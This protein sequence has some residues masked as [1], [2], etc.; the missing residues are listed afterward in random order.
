MQTYTIR[1]GGGVALHV[2]EIGPRDATP[3]LFIHGFSQC[4]LAWRKQTRSDLAREFRLITLDLRGHGASTRP[5]DGYDDPGLWAEDLNAV[6]DTLHLNA[7][8]LVGW[9]Y[10]GVIISDYLRVYGEDRVAGVQLVGAVSRLG[11]PLVSGGFLGSDFLAVVPALFSNDATESV[12]A[13]TRFLRLCMCAEPSTE[14]LYS[15]LGWNALV[16]PYVR[17]GLL[18]RTVDNDHVF[19]G[20]RKPVSLVYGE[21]D[22][23]VSP[24]MCTHLER[25]VRHSEVST[26]ANV[27]HMPFWEDPER[28]NRELRRFTMRCHGIGELGNLVIGKLGVS[29]F[30]NY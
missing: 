24:R 10:A 17:Q 28:F 5:R 8:V 25:L 15:F 22:Q 2:E 29:Q 18:A 12:A 1:G 14:D 20:S 23:I 6:M 19:A 3:I 26:Y 7:P 13:M 11:E 9:S 30:P 27:G 16:P 4:G 21:A